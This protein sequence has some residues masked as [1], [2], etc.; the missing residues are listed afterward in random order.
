MAFKCADL[1]QMNQ[2][3]IAGLFT[4]GVMFTAITFWV[5]Y[6]ERLSFYK[7]LGMALII[8]AVLCVGYKEIEP[9]TPANQSKL[10]ILAV[11]LALIVGLFLTSTALCN[12]HY[13]EVAGFT[14]TQLNV[15]SFM[16]Q[17]LGLYTM[18]LIIVPV[19]TMWD[20][21]LGITC[22]FLQVTANIMLTKAFC[23]G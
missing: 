19:F 23:M 3:C 18:W 8:V 2:G 9:D 21:M 13:P 1:A 16:V 12:R 15:D 20:I 10:I 22:G 6:S 4:S 14:P 7:L 11:V 5:I 17:S